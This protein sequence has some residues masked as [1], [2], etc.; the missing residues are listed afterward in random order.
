[1]T[2]GEHFYGLDD[3]GKREYLKTRDIR[4]EKATPADPGAT[5]G[6]RV[7]IDGADHGVFPYPA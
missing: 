5:K 2:V 7:I 3:D 4:V 1:M 6:V